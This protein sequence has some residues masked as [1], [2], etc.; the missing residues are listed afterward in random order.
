MADDTTKAETLESSA[1]FKH[2]TMS[3][4]SGKNGS[5]WMTNTGKAIQNNVNTAW[6]AG[7]SSL[8][9]D[10]L[11]LNG[12]SRTLGSAYTDQYVLSMSYT[13][14][15][16]YDQLINAG[17]FSILS[18]NSKGEWVNAVKN[19]F[20][21]ASSFVK[22][23]WTSS[24]TLGTYGVDPATKTAWAVLNYNGDFA[25]GGTFSFY[26]PALFSGN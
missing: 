19:N 4:L 17:K 5:T 25:V 1:A 15:S 21:S 8:S 14:G 2:T 10:I 7:T 13:A 24:Y 6:K 20:G 11:S 26:L 12:M 16:S 23:P 9:S 22:G 18:K 3:I